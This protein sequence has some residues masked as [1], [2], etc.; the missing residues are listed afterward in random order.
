M[1]WRVFIVSLYLGVCANA[2]VL[3]IVSA[4]II[5]LGGGHSA[6]GLLAFGDIVSGMPTGQDEVTITI[7][8]IEY[9][10]PA[11]AFQER[12][13]VE[14]NEFPKDTFL[15]ERISMLE[16]LLED[17]TNQLIDLQG[18][19]I[20]VEIELGTEIVIQGHGT[21]EKS[22]KI[23]AASP[24][25]KRRTQKQLVT[26]IDM[27]SSELE[28]LHED[29]IQARLQQAL[30]KHR[31]AYFKETFQR[32]D[33]DS[34]W[35]RQTEYRVDS[36]SVQVYGNVST[37]I[38]LKKGDRFLA[39]P[40]QKDRN[41]VIVDL[42]G[43]LGKVRGQ[44]VSATHNRVERRLQ[45]RLRAR[46]DATQLEGRIAI[47]QR[48]LESLD[49]A[50]L[51]LRMHDVLHGTWSTLNDRDLCNHSLRER[52]CRQGVIQK[53][54]RKTIHKFLKVWMFEVETLEGQLAETWQAYATA[55]QRAL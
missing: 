34:T 20:E 35:Y 46:S 21:A 19:Q 45:K 30:G 5:E 12:V 7:G 29:L 32:Y 18:H 16:K 44:N 13:L 15:A 47:T 3:Y 1:I 43:R 23:R 38:H 8:G 55:R 54:D 39:A 9:N 27:T 22:R 53:I 40:S 48:R 41:W 33:E 10:L 6:Q 25:E 37:G 4:E 24:L 50:I 11:S 2:Q 49:A 17:I 36:Q 26:K 14:N 42:D 28:K 51:A 52:D 31:L